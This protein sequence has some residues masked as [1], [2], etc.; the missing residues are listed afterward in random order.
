MCGY[1]QFPFLSRHYLAVNT[2]SLLVEFFLITIMSLSQIW[3][4]EVAGVTFCD[5]SFESMFFLLIFWSE[6]RQEGEGLRAS[7][8][9]E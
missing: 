6:D 7:F 2:I 4:K 9:T 8:R 3:G 1:Y 5:L